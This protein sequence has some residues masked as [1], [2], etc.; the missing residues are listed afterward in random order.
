MGDVS[1]SPSPPIPI[2]DLDELTDGDPVAIQDPATRIK[3]KHHQLTL[4][5][6]CK[7]YESGA[8]DI[9]ANFPSLRRT[10]RPG[11]S[12]RT[13]VGIIG[14]RA[15]SGKSFV[16]LSLIC[17]TREVLPLAPAV[18]AMPIIQT[19][20]MNTFHISLGDGCRNSAASLLVVPHSLMDQWSSYMT[21][22]SPGLR[23]TIVNSVKALT[24]FEA[25][26]GTMADV[27]LVVCTSTY[28]N[29]VVNIANAC[30]L[31]FARAV[32]DEVDNMDIPGCVKPEA[33]FIWFVTASFGNLMNPRGR[34]KWNSKV[35]QHVWSATGIRSMGFVKSLFLDMTYSM[36]PWMMNMLVVKNDDAFVISSL[37]LLDVEHT[38]VR[39]RTPN[40][41]NLLNGLVD[42]TIINFLNAGDAA[43]A[44][45][46]I[47]A[48]NKDTE[49]NIVM[50]LIDKYTRSLRVLD[51]RHAYI[52]SS[53]SSAPTASTSI[54][55][56]VPFI[57]KKQAETRLKIASI[58]E[59]IETTNSCCICY[60]NI[61]NKSVV[62]CCSNSYCLKCISTW[63]SQKMQCPMCKQAL[64]ITDLLVVSREDSKCDYG[65]DSGSL[66]I[67]NS[68]AKN[69][70]IIIKRRKPGD[71]ILIFSLNDRALANVGN[72]LEAN[73]VKYSYLKGNQTRIASILKSYSKT[74]STETANA[75]ATATTSIDVILINPANYGCGI[76]MERTTD[77]IMLHKFDTEIERQVIG[78][79]HRFGRETPLRVWYLVYDN[80]CQ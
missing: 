23:R 38:I 46:F 35:N 72:V 42:R 52:D 5:H 36:A 11:D 61:A 66:R 62:P 58:R 6:R 45:Q 74:S 76:N 16:V 26:C 39:C 77:I 27:D 32:F 41:I 51:A 24:A 18:H 75:A 4:L 55:S 12:F 48:A 78:R 47:N 63:L 65:I 54:E 19:Y 25:L 50:A 37:A 30:K 57:E 67:E 31:K 22:F 2:V 33:S 53:S 40:T 14:D 56:N 20:G 68:K 44:L 1:R 43:S 13:R 15:G 73:D 3:L 79:A 10:T 49:E 70:E 21:A 34:G 17:P 29:R 9:H 8:I 69:M 71:K 28:Y 80:E 60:E 64:K 59:R 7:M